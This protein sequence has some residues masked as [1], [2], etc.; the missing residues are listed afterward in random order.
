MIMKKYPN[1][2][3]RMRKEREELETPF[4]KPV[5]VPEIG[6]MDILHNLWTEARFATD[7]MAE[8]SVFFTLLMPAETALE[9]RNEA[10]KFTGI[11]TE[12]FNR[13]EET[14]PEDIED[15]KK[16]ASEIIEAYKPFIEYKDRNQEAQTKGKLRSLVWPLFF[17]HTSR[18]ASRWVKRITQ[19]S[20]GDVHY[21]KE[22][23]TTF[24]TRI[25][26]EHTRFIAHLLDPDEFET[27]NKAM[28]LSEEF[29]LLPETPSDDISKSRI[30]DISKEVPIQTETADIFSAAEDILEFKTA[31]ARAIEAAKV[32][33]IIDPR[34]ADHVRR[35]ALKFYDE[36]Q[37][38]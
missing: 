33:S 17:D 11:F 2:K 23:V 25:M 35:E 24:W 13:I 1:L 15:V 5:I 7:I 22:E 18:E 12:L 9:E 32:K 10:I 20:K 21:D 4:E 37:R 28:L 26:E 31:A 14:T 38:V 6:D 19:I 8:H 34:L 16:F 29:A 30:K 27:I 36:L 3:I